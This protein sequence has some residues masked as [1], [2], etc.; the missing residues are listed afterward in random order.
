M[1]MPRLAGAIAL[2]TVFWGAAGHAA[3]GYVPNAWGPVSKGMAGAGIALDGVGPL[4]GANNPAAILGVADQE[5]Q[6]ALF[7]IYAVPRF[8]VGAPAGGSCP[9]G[10]GPLCLNPGSSRGDPEAPL[11][12]FFIP[13]GGMN[14]RVGDRAAFALIVYANGGLNT[15]YDDFPNPGC[16]PP[17]ATEGEGVYCGGVTGI[18]L[19]Q[20]FIAPTYAMQVTP[21]WRLGVSPILALETVEFQGLAAFANPRFSADP[22][23]VKDSGHDYA[24]GW[25]F[26]FGTQ[27]QATDSLSVAAV[28]QTEID[29]GS[30][31]DYAGIL[32]DHGQLD[33]PAYAEFGVAWRFLLR[34]TA[35][36]DVQRVYYSNV[37]AF[38]NEPDAPRRFGA[39]D[40]PGFG[41]DD[42][43]IYKFGL[44]WQASATWTWRA[45]YAHVDPIPLNEDDLFLGLMAQSVMQDQY[46]LGASWLYGQGGAI[47]FSFLY[48]ARNEMEGRNRFVPSQRIQ[49]S[50]EDFELDLSWRHRF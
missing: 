46:A 5:L 2:A 11:N 22:D 26:K 37:P 3:T 50:L 35:A 4:S 16:P 24:L 13:Q 21:R 6:L 31:K 38:G 32:P 27:F 17:P 12:T 1:G 20:Y 30:F 44:S 29:V 33:I 49:V 36:F 48:S 39:D 7:A 14:W 25:G 19:A 10:S 45:G 43:T 23:H 15:T 42:G 28:I 34:W 40:G 9:V 18:D 47:D 41:W 8:E